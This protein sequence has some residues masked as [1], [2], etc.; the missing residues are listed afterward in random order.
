MD[1]LT[2]TPAEIKAIRVALGLTSEDGDHA[3]VL[4]EEREKEAIV[5]GTVSAQGLETHE[6]TRG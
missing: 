4:L 2:V 5:G 1:S 6:K 3:A